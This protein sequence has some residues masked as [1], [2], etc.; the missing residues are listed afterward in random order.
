[1]EGG[2]ARTPVEM[3]ETLGLDNRANQEGHPSALP[4][5]CALTL[6]GVTN[7]RQCDRGLGTESKPLQTACEPKG[8]RRGVREFPVF[9]SGPGS[10]LARFQVA[11]GVAGLRVSAQ[12]FSTCRVGCGS[13]LGQRIRDVEEGIL[14][15]SGPA[16]QL[17]TSSTSAG[18]NPYDSQKR[19]TM[20]AR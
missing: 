1:M 12:C 13:L 4:A 18:Q 10:F 19:E 3:R 17:G 2:K 9:Y 5:A 7:F 20:C 16:I 8:S 11:P 15:R 6:A 14:T